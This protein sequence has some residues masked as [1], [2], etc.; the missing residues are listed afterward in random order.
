MTEDRAKLAVAQRYVRAADPEMLE[1]LPR[2]GGTDARYSREY[3]SP[4]ITAAYSKPGPIIRLFHTII[5]RN[6]RDAIRVEDS[7][8]WYGP[9]AVRSIL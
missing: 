2:L 6:L 3:G 7:S 8:A 4:A 1:Q 5:P 9:P